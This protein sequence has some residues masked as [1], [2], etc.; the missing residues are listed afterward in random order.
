MNDSDNFK[1]LPSNPDEFHGIWLNFQSTWNFW[2]SAYDVAVLFLMSLGL[3]G[4]ILALLTLFRSP[5][6]Q[7][8][9][10]SYHKALVL[11]DLVYCV[12]W[13]VLQFVDKKLGR[14]GYRFDN[15]V[16][17]YYSGILHRVITSSCGY[18]V[19]YMTLFIA[20]DRFIGLTF[21]L[22]YQRFNRSKVA[23]SLIAVGVGLSFLLHSWTPW[24]ERVVTKI[25]VEN[26]T[27]TFSW[28]KPIRNGSVFQ[29]MLV[30]K[31]IYNG[32]VRISYPIALTVLTSVVCVKFLQRN[33]RRHLLLGNKQSNSLSMKSKSSCSLL[34]E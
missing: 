31:N 18:T 12:N 3:I 32:A 25:T 29:E 26:D 9:S 22:W 33:K 6:T 17:A 4:G 16:L 28:R 11:A 19:L 34:G 21:Y 27:A 24:F 1:A 13:F 10:F 15:P 8:P 14:T 20:V 30:M 7:T 23:K 2:L 5:Q